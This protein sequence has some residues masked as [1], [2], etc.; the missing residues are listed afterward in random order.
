FGRTRLRERHGRVPKRG[1]DVERQHAL[2][3][4][5]VLAPKGRAPREQPLSG[6]LLDP[7]TRRRHG[8]LSSWR[9][10]AAMRNREEWHRSEMD[11]FEP[12]MS[13]EGDVQHQ[14]SSLVHR[15]GERSAGNK[16]H[17]IDYGMLIRLR[18]WVR[19]RLLR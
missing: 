11:R 2:H 5:R 3:H 15:Q 6:R 19:G 7:D 4:W 17:S 10:I 9:Q 12:R 16:L 18:G 14:M 1:Q 13:I 8:E